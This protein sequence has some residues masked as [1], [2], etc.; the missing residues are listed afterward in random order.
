MRI[1]VA[2]ANGFVRSSGLSVPEAEFNAI[3]S[4]TAELY[5]PLNLTAA[6]ISA[7]VTPTNY[8]YPTGFSQRYG[9]TGNGTTDDTAAIN[10]WAKVCTTAGIA[11]KLQGGTF[12]ISSPVVFNVGADGFS[13][14]GPSSTACLF[15]ISSSFS[16][17]TIAVQIKG[18]GSTCQWRIGGFMIEPSS[19]GSGSAVLGLQI[20]DPTTASVGLA[21]YQASTLYDIEVQ[22][23]QTLWQFTH[24]RLIRVV[25]CAGWNQGYSVSSDSTCL[26]ITQNGSFTGDL[27]FDNCQ[28]VIP[29]TVL[30][31]ACARI[32]S[33][34]GPYN[35]TNGNCQI[36]GIRFRSCI[37]YHGQYGLQIYAAA[38]S[39]V[40]DIWVDSGSQFEGDYGQ[41]VTG[42]GT[43]S[44]IRLESNGSGTRMEDVHIDHCYVNG[45]FAP[46]SVSAGGVVL[47]CTGSGSIMRSI[48]VTHNYLWAN[49]VELVATYGVSNTME[50]I[51]IQGNI[52]QDCANQS[53][54][55]GAAIIINGVTGYVVADNTCTVGGANQKPN[56]V[57]NLVAGSN[58]VCHDNT[59]AAGC[60]ATG[61]VLNGLG[62]QVVTASVPAAPATY[63]FTNTTGGPVNLSLNVNGA[64]I[65][66]LSIG[67]Y[68]LSAPPAAYSLYT[69]PTGVT[70]VFAYTGAT[71]IIEYSPL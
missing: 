20:G 2:A 60:V 37:F 36:A 53:G 5:Q 9:V 52:I 55:T 24:C 46:S 19:G 27:T 70:A 57:V 63:T 71:P 67:G 12:L 11:G 8:A 69:V 45:G 42:A 35:D 34:V 48:F 29:S 17:G 38:S 21:G 47:T 10:N 30:N 23:F 64:T 7:G 44:N 18:N 25:D 26:N 62:N 4:M 39:Y 40:S 16:G 3:D 15:S 22:G 33:P 32:N 54:G 13:L 50:A 65:T 56:Y 66:A 49:N 61:I 58:G 68:S 1:P 28:W 31:G 43:I 6:E 14:E 51:V 59:A 41:G